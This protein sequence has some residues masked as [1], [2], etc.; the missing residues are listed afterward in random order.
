MPVWIGGCRRSSRLVLWVAPLALPS[1]RFKFQLASSDPG[2]DE[3][4]FILGLVSAPPQLI[5][6]SCLR[7]AVAPTLSGR[8]S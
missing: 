1:L 5:F 6:T 8:N 3:H 4:L 2:I 7:I